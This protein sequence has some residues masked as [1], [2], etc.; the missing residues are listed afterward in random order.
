MMKLIGRSEATHRTLSYRGAHI[1]NYI[2]RNVPTDVSYPCFKNIVKTHILA[3]LIS[4]S[5][6][7]I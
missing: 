6:H 3:H 4:H 1:L 2:S 7:N 5:R